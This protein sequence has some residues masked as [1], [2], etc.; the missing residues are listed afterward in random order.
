MIKITIY[1]R[2]GIVDDTLRSMSIDENGNVILSIKGSL[3]K[4]GYR[5]L[6]LNPSLIS[7]PDLLLR[8]T[9]TKE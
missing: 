5:I 3:G 6:P 8:S 1:H 7:V 9:S 2:D 4:P